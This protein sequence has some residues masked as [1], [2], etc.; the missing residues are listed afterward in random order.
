VEYIDLEQ[1]FVSAIR[2]DGSEKEH[3]KKDL[4][5]PLVIKHSVEGTTL[6]RLLTL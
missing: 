6:N 3:L 4:W 5:K 1:E 2:I